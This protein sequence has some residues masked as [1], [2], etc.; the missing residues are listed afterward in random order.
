[1]SSLTSTPS[2]PSS[3]DHAAP[4]V[5]DFGP[6]ATK[7]LDGARRQ[8]AEIYAGPLMLNTYLAIGIVVAI[9]FS[10]GLMVLNFRTQAMFAN[11]KPLIIRIDE[12]GRAQAISY[13]AAAAFRLQDREARHFLTRFVV[14]HYTRLRATIKRDFPD[15]LYF[16]SDRIP[17]IGG[18]SLLQITMA[19]QERARIVQRYLTDPTLEEVDVEV[20]NVTLPELTPPVYRASVDF[21]KRYYAAGSR[22][23]VRSETWVAQ[24]QFRLR[25]SVP[26]T[27]IPV[28]PL[29]F[30]IESLRVD[31]AFH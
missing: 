24:I 15:S 20:K 14:L 29:G 27:F 9:L 30:E 8:F 19:E 13:D 26:N 7:T 22:E 3:V 28:N 4:T 31:Q 21:E 12:V 1:M 11:V 2:S 10:A 23:P 18:A 25:E 6:T 5:A 16:L 17:E